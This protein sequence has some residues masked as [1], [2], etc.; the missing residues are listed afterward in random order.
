MRDSGVRGILIYCADYHC[1]HSVAI[2]GEAAASLSRGLFAGSVY[3]PHGRW[4]F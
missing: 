2:A 3:E 1:S 4:L